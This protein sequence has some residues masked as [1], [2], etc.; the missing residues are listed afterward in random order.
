MHLRMGDRRR[1]SGWTKAGYLPE[2]ILDLLDI[3][4][5]WLTARG[6]AMDLHAEYDSVNRA[7]F[8]LRRNG[9][10]RSRFVERMLQWRAG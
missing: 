10:V 7:L 5:G 2:R 1:T 8:R 4:G 3:D 6:I 9:K